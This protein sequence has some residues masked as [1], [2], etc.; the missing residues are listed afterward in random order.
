MGWHRATDDRFVN[1]DGG[2]ANSQASLFFDAEARVGVFVAANV[3]NALDT[4]SSPSG[5]SLLDGPTAR[6]MAM[7]ILSMATRSGGCTRSRRCSS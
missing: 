7:T 3:V 5:A 2:T 4:F 1:L 6:G